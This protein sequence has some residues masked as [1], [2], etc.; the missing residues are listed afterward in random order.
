MTKPSTWTS[1][2]SPRC[3]Y[4]ALSEAW[5]GFSFSRPM[6]DM[7]LGHGELIVERV[8]MVCAMP[9]GRAPLAAQPLQLSSCGA[10][11]DGIRLLGLSAFEHAGALQ[12]KAAGLAAESSNHSL[13]A[14]EG[15]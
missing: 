15:R 11:D 5:S 1:N 12:H 2:R 7:P 3:A 6:T 4:H 9:D 13:E 10:G 14:D 8:R